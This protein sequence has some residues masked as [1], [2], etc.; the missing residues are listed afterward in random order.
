MKLH[1][2]LNGLIPLLLAAAGAFAADDAGPLCA[3]RTAIEQ[4]YYQ[5]RT[6]QKAP[7]EQVLPAEAIRRAVER[8]LVRE[9]ALRRAYGVEI[10]AAQIEAEVKRI[11]SSTRAPDVLAELKRA[12]GDD[13]G[14]FGRAVARP[15]LVERELRA[16]I[17]ND[18]ALHAAKRRACEG[19]RQ[20]CLEKKAAGAEAGE[21]TALLKRCPDGEA[22]E[23]AWELTPASALDSS[24]KR[25][26]AN[27]EDLPGELR[28][29]LSAQLRQSGDI[30]SVIE[31]PQSFLV[32]V[33]VARSAEELRAVSLSIPKLSLESWLAAQP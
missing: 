12:V 27:F 26:R 10:S 33:A 1:S 31:T 17:E 16:R 13:R 4:V 14:R 24:K 5:H 7:F 8:D 19:C 2:L 32:F 18:D 6:G 21:I 3:D 25:G 22:A 29:I 9:A 28:Q 20:R 11:E 30:T 23:Q 15:A